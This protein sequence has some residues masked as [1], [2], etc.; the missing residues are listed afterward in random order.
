MR[1]LLNI[2]KPLQYIFYAMAVLSL[3]YIVIHLY[4]H[5]DRDFVNGRLLCSFRPRLDQ[6]VQACGNAWRIFIF[7]A[8][9]LFAFFSAALAL[10]IS[11]LP[12]R[13]TEAEIAEARFDPYSAYSRVIFSRMYFGRVFSIGPSKYDTRTEK[14]RDAGDLYLFHFGVA[15]KMQGLALI[16]LLTLV[17]P[18]FGPAAMRSPYLQAVLNF[19]HLNLLFLF[20]VEAALF[21]YAKLLR[22]NNNGR[23]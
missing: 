8:A 19:V 18:E 16:A 15:N 21:L 23:V 13:L 1:K 3:F 6:I 17:F 9:A 4:A 20:I 22:R 7:Q 14:L 11:V 10:G 12:R 5:G 2:M